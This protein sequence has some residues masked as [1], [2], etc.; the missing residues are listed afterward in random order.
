MVSRRPV[1]ISPEFHRRRVRTGCRVLSSAL[2]RSGRSEGPCEVS[3]MRSLLEGQPALSFC[4]PLDPMR[5]S[6]GGRSGRSSPPGL[7]GLRKEPQ[8]SIETLVSVV[9]RKR[10]YARTEFS[11]VICLSCRLL[12]LGKAATVGICSGTGCEAGY[13]ALWLQSRPK[14]GWWEVGK[15]ATFANCLS[16]CRTCRFTAHAV[17]APDT[18]ASRYWPMR[19]GDLMLLGPFTI[20]RGD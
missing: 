16:I 2:I 17:S 1:A 7:S 5:I 10:L 20:S 15:C 9:H 3:Q 8:G 19:K 12:A 4:T 13:A 14:A 11:R 18:I 6:A